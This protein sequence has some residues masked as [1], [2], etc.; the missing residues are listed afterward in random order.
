M[1]FE[2]NKNS[3]R[4]V[5]DGK[6]VP[7]QPGTLSEDPLEA[8]VTESLSAKPELEP[9]ADRISIPQKPSEGQ[10]Q[11]I[12]NIQEATDTAKRALD[13]INQLRE[14]QLEYVQTA[15]ATP[16]GEQSSDLSHEIV[17]LQTEIT[18]V[19]SRATYNGSSVVNAS[20]FY[21]FDDSTTDTHSAVSVPSSSSQ[22]GR[23]VSPTLSQENAATAEDSL[24]ENLFSIRSLD[25]ANSAAADKSTQLGKPERELNVLE[26]AQAKE[27]QI[28]SQTPKD[29][30]EARQ[31]ASKIAQ[32]LSSPFNRES[33]TLAIIDGISSGLDE[34]RVNKLLVEA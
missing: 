28:A 7:S 34:E 13:E 27:D 18:D 3:T 26:K 29:I 12:S 23:M 15:K 22:L 9:Y 17:A 8:T 10:S 2:I 32:K 19:A 21:T 33:N 6:S 4:L 14:T 1:D 24:E 25:D 31:L 20:S 11:T 16:Y 30:S 5:I